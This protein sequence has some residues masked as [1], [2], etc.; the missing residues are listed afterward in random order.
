MGVLVIL[1]IGILPI[2]NIYTLYKFKKEK[3][4][5]ESNIDKNG[6][7][8]LM[9]YSISNDTLNLAY[10]L[11]KGESPNLQ[12]SKGYT[13]LMYA[14]ANGYT[15]SVGLL[16][17]FNA[18]KLL[19]TKKG[20]KAIDFAK[21][22]NYPNVVELLNSEKSFI[23]A[24]E[25]MQIKIFDIFNIKNNNEDLK[26]KCI[27]Y[28]CIGGVAILNDLGGKN[29]K[30]KSAIDSLVNDSKKITKSLTAK[31]KNIVN[32]EFELVEILKNF[33]LEAEVDGETTVNGLAGFEAL[34]FINAEKII[35]DIQNNSN[36]SYGVVGYTGLAISNK[37]F[38][39]EKTKL[40]LKELTLL[41]PKFV[42]DLVNSL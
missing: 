28:L 23:E 25:K 13:A 12:D 6:F 42:D 34:Y 27:F 39:K 22:N 29:P 3:E 11:R 16:L 26:L 32:D 1:I 8:K 30:I 33:P 18:D 7:T 40:N 36:G 14:A 15:D 41:M 2:V 35:L 9:Y 4:E 20:N 19:E 31:V 37:I 21:K 38:G 10:A 17:E 5:V 24:L